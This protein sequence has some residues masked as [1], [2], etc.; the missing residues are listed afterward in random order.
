MTEDRTSVTNLTGADMNLMNQVA[1]YTNYLA[2]KD[3]EMSTM[4]KTA[5]QI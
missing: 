1:E 5:I 3:L 2:T 4:E